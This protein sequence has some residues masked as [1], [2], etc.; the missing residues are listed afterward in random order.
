MFKYRDTRVS[1]STDR[2]Y[3]L[4]Y[5]YYTFLS[6][7]IHNKYIRTYT[8]IGTYVHIAKYTREMYSRVYGCLRVCG[9]L[10]LKIHVYMQT[11]VTYTYMYACMYI[12]NIMDG[13]MYIHVYIAED[14]H[15]NR[16]YLRLQVSIAQ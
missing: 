10:Y 8:D 2:K 6:L 15:L 16:V 4:M 1:G 11:G 3:I 9:R 5:L 7:H 12:Y 13:W 14:K